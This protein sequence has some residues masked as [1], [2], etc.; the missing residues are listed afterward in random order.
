MLI[1]HATN[2]LGNTSIFSAL[3]RAIRTPA[4]SW[5]DPLRMMYITL[6][7]VVIQVPVR[8]SSNLFQLPVGLSPGATR[9]NKS[10]C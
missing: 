3:T 4:G 1:L 2:T 5:S 9:Q 10:K 7:K 6:P 8:S